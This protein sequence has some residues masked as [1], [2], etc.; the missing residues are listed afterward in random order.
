MWFAY[1]LIISVVVANLA[2]HSVM[3][4]APYRRVF[5][6][7]GT[8]AFLAYGVGILSN[9]IW[10]GSRGAML[11]KRPPMDSSTRC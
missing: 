8:A 1:T 2:A 4:G 9:G 10:K 11:S 7:A 3:P 5:R 6:V